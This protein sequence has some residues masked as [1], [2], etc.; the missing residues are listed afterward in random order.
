MHPFT[1][2]LL[3]EIFPIYDPSKYIIDTPLQRF[4]ILLRLQDCVK[5]SNSGSL[6]NMSLRIN[7]LPLKRILTYGWTELD[8]ES[9]H[10]VVQNLRLSDL[11]GLERVYKVVAPHAKDAGHTLDRV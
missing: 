5:R 3:V 8:D 4:A 1:C 2:P 11:L 6:N 7:R 10:S 9:T